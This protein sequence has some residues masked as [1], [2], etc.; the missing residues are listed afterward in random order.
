MAIAAE[1][2]PGDAS[3]NPVAECRNVAVENPFK[4]AE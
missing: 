3:S 2:F 1:R 4:A